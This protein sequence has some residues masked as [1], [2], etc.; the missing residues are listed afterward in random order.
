MGSGGSSEVRCEPKEK[1]KKVSHVYTTE[2]VQETDDEKIGGI[3]IGT[4]ARRVVRDIKKMRDQDIMLQKEILK[5][6]T[7]MNAI[8][9]RPKTPPQVVNQPPTEENITSPTKLIKKKRKETFQG[10]QPTT[11]RQR[12]LSQEKVKSKK[13]KSDASPTTVLDLT[14]KTRNDIPD[15]YT[16]EDYQYAKWIEM[17]LNLY[18]HL[19][20]IAREG[21]QCMVPPPWQSVKNKDGDI[22]YQNKETNQIQD[23]HPLDD[24]F[25]NKYLAATKGDDYITVEE[26]VL[27]KFKPP[28]P[29]SPETTVICN[30]SVLFL[31]VTTGYTIQMMAS[32]SGLKY[33]VDGAARPPVRRLNLDPRSKMLRFPELGKGVTLPRESANVLIT[34]IRRLCELSR[35]VTHNLGAQNTD[36][37]NS[38]MSGGSESIDPSATSF[39][40]ERKDW[41]IQQKEIYERRGV[42]PPVPTASRRKPKTPPLSQQ[43]APSTGPDHVLNP[44][45]TPPRTPPLSPLPD[46]ASSKK[47]KKSAV[48]KPQTPQEGKILT[49]IELYDQCI[50]RLQIHGI[51]EGQLFTPG[52]GF[53]D[54]QFEEMLKE[55]LGY[56]AIERYKITA[57]LDFLRMERLADQKNREIEQNLTSQSSCDINPLDEKGTNALD[58]RS[59]EQVEEESEINNYIT[60]AIGQE[61]I[62][63]EYLCTITGEILIDPTC[64]CDGHVYEHL[65]IKSWLISH[66]TS[67]NTNKK[68]NNKDLIPNLALRRAIMGWKEKM[69][70]EHPQA[71][72]LSMPS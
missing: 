72:P 8:Q 29:Q 33:T 1:N 7:A 51:E 17:D 66:D 36:L 43:L 37:P 41:V 67:P 27:E 57:R 26:Y 46:T 61:H 58:G 68:L 54:S 6:T 15:E 62:P 64:T 31:D 10:E 49:E 16:D 59:P 5:A 50:T 56:S 12:S 2:K 11:S 53:T 14:V 3:G 30:S 71:S 13:Q 47:K 34:A 25:K 20:P 4:G 48:S 22:V 55:D 32:L 39:I 35:G 70:K 21:I 19:M 24:Y 52:A 38:P 28:R 23:N 69:L 18:P 42:S 44:V 45:R 40:P 65:A 9:T 63:E 60:T